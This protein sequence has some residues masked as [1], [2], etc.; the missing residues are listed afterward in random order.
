MLPIKNPFQPVQLVDII[1]AIDMIAMK[2]KQRTAVS[3]LWQDEKQT[4]E[5]IKI[6]Q[7]KTGER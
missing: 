6:K 2:S 4:H 5:R 3:T 7:L 1:L